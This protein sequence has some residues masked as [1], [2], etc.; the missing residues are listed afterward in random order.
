MVASD[1][2]SDLAA[3]QMTAA[4]LPYLPFGDSDAIE[5]GRP[6]KVLGFPFGR[7]AEVAKQAEPT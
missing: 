5:A 6:V 3:L 7:Q 2:E 1:A 4:D